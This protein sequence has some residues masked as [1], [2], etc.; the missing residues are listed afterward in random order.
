MHGT[1]SRNLIEDVGDGSLLPE[2]EFMPML[3]SMHAVKL[4]SIP[5]DYCTDLCI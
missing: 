3:G 4:P 1:C 2:L 5:D